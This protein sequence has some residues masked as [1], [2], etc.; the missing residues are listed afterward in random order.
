[1]SRRSAT[2][3]GPFHL[4]KFGDGRRWMHGVSDNK[5]SR[6]TLVRLAGI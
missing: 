5:E 4:G 6:P 2:S 1:M 3:E